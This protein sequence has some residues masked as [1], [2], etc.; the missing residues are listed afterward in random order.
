MRMDHWWKGG[1]RGNQ[2]TLKETWHCATSSNIN[3]SPTGVGSYR[4]LRN[5]KQEEGKDDYDYE[6]QEE[7]TSRKTLDL[8]FKL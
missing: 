2:S 6:E 1:N 8:T 4:D 5:K 3:S 7:T